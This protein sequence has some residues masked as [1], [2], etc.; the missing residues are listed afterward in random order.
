MK[1]KLETG[2]HHQI[3]VQFA[4]LGYPLCG[5]QRYGLQEKMQICLFAYHL[6]FVHPV[7]K[8]LLKFTLMPKREGYWTKFTV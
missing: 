2:R 3:R 5:D 8:E 6:E 4:N 1:I 7:T